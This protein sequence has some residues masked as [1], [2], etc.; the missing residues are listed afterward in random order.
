M[1]TLINAK[2]LRDALNTAATKDIR[3]FLNCVFLEVTPG[4]TRIVSTDGTVM[5]V[6]GHTN[7]HSGD[8]FTVLI[9]ND[10]IKSLDKKM[11]IYELKNEGST[12]IIHNQIFTPIDGRFPDWRRV[13]PNLSDKRHDAEIAHQFQPDNIA[14]FAKIAGKE[15]LVIEN[16]NASV[17]RILGRGDFVGV[18]M[19]LRPE[20]I[21]KHDTS[22]ID[23]NLWAS[24]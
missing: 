14:K 7:D 15:T 23:N 4:F 17:V 5:S 3:N 22:I 24:Y 21:K 18:I 8:K 2:M 6:Q 16:A 1:I 11:H 12:W 10:T 13:L 20:W 9:P 19:G